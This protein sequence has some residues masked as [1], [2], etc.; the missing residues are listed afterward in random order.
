MRR[1][2]MVED[3]P[4]L[5]EH[6]NFRLWHETDLQPCPQFGRYR[7]KADVGRIGHFGRD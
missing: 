7:G 5:S 1:P 6:A 3:A 4:G 2:L